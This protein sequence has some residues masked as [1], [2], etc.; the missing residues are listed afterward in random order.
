[1][2]MAR[3]ILEIQKAGIAPDIW[4]LEGME[5]PEDVSRVV[6]ACR[7]NGTNAGIIV[8]GRGEDSEKV[9]AWLRAGANISGVIG[10]AI[11]RTVFWN[12]IVKYY[13]GEITAEVASQEIAS[14][15]KM[16]VDLWY[17]ARNK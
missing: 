4:K 10:F 15:Y 3:G 16:F 1:E 5:K 17:E 2:L 7:A 8:L 9:K 13:K 14:T 6:E 11:G 12:S